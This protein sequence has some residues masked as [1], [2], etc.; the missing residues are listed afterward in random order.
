MINQKQINQQKTNQTEKIIQTSNSTNKKNITTSHKKLTQLKLKDNQAKENKE[1]KNLYNSYIQSQVSRYKKYKYIIKTIRRNIMSGYF[2]EKDFY[3]KKTVSDILNKAKTR[4]VSV[5]YE[6]VMQNDVSEYIKSYNDYD[7]II[8][9]MTFLC[10]VYEKRFIFKPNFFK[11]TYE[12]YFLYENLFFKQRLIHKQVSNFNS[13][14]IYKSNKLMKRLEMESLNK[15]ESYSKFL[16]SEVCDNINNEYGN[17][18]SSVIKIKTTTVNRRSTVKLNKDFLNTNPNLNLRNRQVKIDVNEEVHRKVEDYIDIDMSEEE[19]MIGMNKILNEIENSCRLKV[20]SKLNKDILNRKSKEICYQESNCHGDEYDVSLHYNQVS[21]N[22]NNKL[23]SKI[24]NQSKEKNER[25]NSNIF[26]ITQFSNDTNQIGLNISSQAYKSPTNLQIPNSKNIINKEMIESNVILNNLNSFKYNYENN[27]YHRS[28]DNKIKRFFSTQ[29]FHNRLPFITQ[30]TPKAEK[31]NIKSSY[32]INIIQPDEENNLESES[33]SQKV[34]TESTNNNNQLI[35]IND[36]NENIKNNQLVTE[37]SLLNKTYKSNDDN[38]IINKGYNFNDIE[39]DSKIS[40]NNAK[41]SIHN[42]PINKNKQRMPMKI[43]L[44]NNE[45][46][47][48]STSLIELEKKREKRK[49]LIKKFINSNPIKY[50]NDL[51]ES[52][53]SRRSEIVKSITN[54]NQYVNDKRIN[55]YK[56]IRELSTSIN[57]KVIKSIIK[58]DDL[59]KGGFIYKHSNSVSSMR[60]DKEELVSYKES[61]S[62]NLKMKS[63]KEIDYNKVFMNN[64]ITTNSLGINQKHNEFKLFQNLKKS[65]GKDKPQPEMGKSHFQKKIMKKTVKVNQ[66]TG[67]IEEKNNNSSSLQMSSFGLYELPFM[68]SLKGSLNRKFVKYDKSKLCSIR[69]KLV[70]K[71]N[72]EKKVFVTRLTKLI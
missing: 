33:L 36:F 4:L 60:S 63:K 69:S 66:S 24:F 53:T 70:F 7:Q 34:K 8:K 18:N 5:Y 38:T 28:S 39:S 43:N 47:V 19:S 27:H 62:N 40:L 21:N 9:K 32:N 12:K 65:R 71:G 30:T 46:P 10:D 68:I 45:K 61:N 20:L 44:K 42:S 14:N 16:N 48:K 67:Y 50:S 59:E 57:K 3:Y 41:S 22:S 49:C 72:N 29:G 1:K 54:L 31:K 6:L 52:M 11:L 35:V 17:L 64:N 25:L 13:Y 26:S 51:D 55:K 56:K 2:I 58:R 15:S 37:R 23:Y